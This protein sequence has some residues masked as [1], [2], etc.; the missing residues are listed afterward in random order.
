MGSREPL[1]IW[2]AA[3]L[4]GGRVY[5]W[6]GAVMARIDGDPA[7]GFTW[8]LTANAGVSSLPVGAGEE[9]SLDAARLAAEDAARAMVAEMAAALGGSVTWAA[10]GGE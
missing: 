9:Q 10:E 3:S 6:F 7:D 2:R 4:D 8:N 5:A 1:G